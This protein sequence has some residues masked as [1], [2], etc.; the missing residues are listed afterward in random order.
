MPDIKR[1]SF[2]LLSFEEL[3]A[4]LLKCGFEKYRARQI[5]D[6]V[7]R[8]KIFD[9]QGMATIPK[10]LRDFLSGAFLF[11]ETETLGR[12]IDGDMTGKFLHRLH[13]GNLVECVLLEAPAEG[14]GN[15]QDAVRK[16]T[17]WLRLRLPF[18][19]VHN[20]RLCKKLKRRRDNI[21]G[22]S[23]RRKGREICV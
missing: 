2:F 1:P 5:F 10:K 15:T 17:G 14:G 3:Q 7:Y 13:D 12:N 9:P 23:L 6:C 18:L 19:R 21:P 20:A 16:H 8:M 4:E 11:S 22:P